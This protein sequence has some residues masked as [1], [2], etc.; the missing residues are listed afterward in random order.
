MPS[1]VRMPLVERGCQQSVGMAW[2]PKSGHPRS[3]GIPT[4]L[5]MI[6]ERLP[7][8][9]DTDHAKLCSD[10]SMLR[11]PLPP[12][13]PPPLLK[14]LLF[15]DCLVLC[16]YCQGC[17]LAGNHHMREICAVVL[18]VRSTSVQSIKGAMRK[19]YGVMSLPAFLTPP[20]LLD[21][22]PFLY[23]LS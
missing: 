4:W 17:H 12:P 8:K 7:K 10:A 6:S 15:L 1:Y 9:S 22:P 18:A 16:S 14:P 2:Q 19:M 21:N 3:I 23:P 13:H 20:S 5:G 11:A